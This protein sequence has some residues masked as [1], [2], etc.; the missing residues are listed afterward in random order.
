MTILDQLAEHA[1]ERVAEA[2]RMIP[3]EGIRRQ[4]LS[5]PKGTYA[6]DNV[7]KKPYISLICE[8]K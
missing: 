1:R 7:L 8:C 5:L 3:L 6:F 4:A 2:K